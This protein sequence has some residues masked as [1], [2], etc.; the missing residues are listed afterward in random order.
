MFLCDILIIE[1]FAL[2]FQMIDRSKFILLR[3]SGKLVIR[4][5]PN[6]NSIFRFC[7][8]TSATSV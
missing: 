2:S 7:N 5:I 6:C 4:F 1:E 3:K 8:S